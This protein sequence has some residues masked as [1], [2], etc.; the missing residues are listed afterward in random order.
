VHLTVSPQARKLPLDH[1]EVVLDNPHDRP[2][3][4]ALLVGLGAFCIIIG[5]PVLLFAPPGSMNGQSLTWGWV[6]I[7]MGIL[8]LY[9]AWFQ[10]YRKWPQRLVLLPERRIRFE[11]RTRAPVEASYEDIRAIRMF[12][13][14]PP[15]SPVPFRFANVSLKSQGRSAFMLAF[16][17]A[18]GLRRDF[19]SKMDFDPS[20]I[21][22]SPNVPMNEFD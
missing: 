16:D 12:A 21:E 7:A 8:C 22:R 11:F 17:T 3:T 9:V 1:A 6:S 5:P 4:L 19:V 14:M 2:L 20:I 10:F 18:R 15:Y 13:K